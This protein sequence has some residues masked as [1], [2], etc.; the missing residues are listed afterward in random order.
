MSGG[1]L[2]LKLQAYLLTPVGSFVLKLDQI[3]SISSDH[4]AMM[5]HLNDSVDRQ[6]I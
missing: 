1:F 6:A 5:P 4:P 3:I 2:L